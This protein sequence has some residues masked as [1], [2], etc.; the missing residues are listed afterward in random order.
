M[1][2]EEAADLGDNFRPAFKDTNSV[3]SQVQM[4]MSPKAFSLCWLRNYAKFRKTFAKF[5]N[6]P[7]VGRN[8]DKGASTLLEAL[9][10]LR[11]PSQEK[12]Y[13]TMSHIGKF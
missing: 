5:C 13:S 11:R 3:G 9:I 10:P 7:I 1:L 8:E 12:I 6:H 2:I 4:T